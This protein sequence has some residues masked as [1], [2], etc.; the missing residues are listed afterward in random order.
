V[1]KANIRVLSEDDWKI[2]KLL[3]LRSLQESPDSFGS[4]YER[5]HQFQDKEWLFLLDS[6]GGD[7]LALPLVAELNGSA[8]GLAWGLIHEPGDQI[9]HVYQMWVSPDT[10][11]LGVGKLL[12]N[13]II[14]WAK[15]TDLQ[16]LSLAVTT[17]NLPA[18][19]LYRS[20]GFLPHGGL[21]ELRSEST[22][23]VQP[24]ML[25]LSA[26]VA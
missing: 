14:V 24:M 11:G 25:E 10:R 22:V 21:K 15:S 8:L 23:R 20:S 13:R 5:E 2:Y 19:K 4:T 18:V 16:A 6:N 1:S 12:L 7:K 17:T 3:R 26:Y 9:A